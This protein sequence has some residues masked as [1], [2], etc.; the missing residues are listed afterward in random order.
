MEL[1]VTS[2]TFTSK[3]KAQG[4]ERMTWRKTFLTCYF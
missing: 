1:N 2:V 4:S 3:R